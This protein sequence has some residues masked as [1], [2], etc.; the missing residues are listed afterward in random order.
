MHW[1]FHCPVAEISSIIAGNYVLQQKNY[2]PY[3]I[4]VVALQKC[5]F[6]WQMYFGVQKNN[7]VVCENRYRILRTKLGIWT[8]SYESSFT[9]ELYSFEAG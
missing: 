1:V 6:E 9:I 8:L 4:N 5:Y 7:D 3:R 2:V